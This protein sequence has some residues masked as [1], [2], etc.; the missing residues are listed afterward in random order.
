MKIL[1]RLSRGLNLGHDVNLNTIANSTHNYTGSDL[2]EILL[3][4]HEEAVKDYLESFSSTDK[5][6]NPYNPDQ[7]SIKINVNDSSTTPCLKHKKV[8]ITEIDSFIAERN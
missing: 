4:S 1:T 3:T 2:E 5:S 7:F 6:N 8:K